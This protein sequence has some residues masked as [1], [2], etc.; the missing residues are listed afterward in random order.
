VST[1]QVPDFAVWFAARFMDRSLP[2]ITPALGRRNRH[3]TEK[4]RRVLG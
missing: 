3:A 2:D 4:V 1:R